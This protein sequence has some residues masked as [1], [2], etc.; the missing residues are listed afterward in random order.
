MNPQN[1]L[2]SLADLPKRNYMHPQPQ[3]T[4][5]SLYRPT[6]YLAGIRSWTVPVLALLAALLAALMF[7][8]YAASPVEAQKQQEMPGVE[9]GDGTVRIGDDVFA[10]DGCVRAGDVVA[11][12]CD[13]S[14]E[15]Q[16]EDGQ[17]KSEPDKEKPSGDDSGGTTV[18]KETTATETTGAGTT[19]QNTTGALRT[20]GGA[21]Q[22]GSTQPGSTSED[23]EA[24]PPALPDDAEPATVERAVDGDT[25]ELQEPLD[26]YDRVRLIGVNTP[27][28]E[29]EGGS[30][31]PGAEEASRFT[32]DTLEGKEVVLET[33]QEVEDDYGRLLAYV[34][35]VPK[36]GEP[37]FFNRTLVADGYA[38]VMTVEPNDTYAECFEAQAKEGN[39]GPE[40][41]QRN[42]NK[43]GLLGRLR[44]LLS[45]ETPGEMGETAGPTVSED[46]YLE[47]GLTRGPGSTGLETTEAVE[48]SEGVTVEEKTAQKP[49]NATGGTTDESTDLPIANPEAEDPVAIPPESCPGATVVLR[50]FGTNGGAQSEPFEVT[51]GTF[52]VRAD[53]QGEDPAD[54]RLDVQVLDTKTQEPVEEFDQRSVGSYDTTIS[55]GPGSYLLN[56]QP[57]SSSYEVTVFDCADQEPEQGAREQGS[58][59]DVPGAPLELDSSTP[60]ETEAG[61]SEAP[62]DQPVD[63]P[64][65]LEFAVGDEP[66][67]SGDTGKP[68][69]VALPTQDGPSGEV[70]VLPDTG[71]PIPG[72]G[73][74]RTVVAGTLAIAAGVAGLTAFVGFGRST[75]RRSKTDGR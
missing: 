7:L 69:D 29:G 43:D 49:L 35:V 48:S 75:G 56:L 53:L 70:A 16:Q 34:W 37:E 23:I 64:A 11:G 63:Q 1:S 51:G 47:N 3:S 18:Q 41:A 46:Q 40:E 24:C 71:G 50:P 74:L 67:S 38:E 45:S 25:I 32:A 72:T 27:E 6:A 21:T 14:S 59:E 26:G 39:S 44:D 13:A 30:P 12:D 31:E 9:V 10:G 60:P 66:V 8:S 22:L 58:G 42:E 54:A 61:G 33:G 73:L 65:E 55:E 52:I 62:V 57:K 68:V 2:G 20:E 17:E 36:T 4:S 19:I 5:P 15:N 28:M